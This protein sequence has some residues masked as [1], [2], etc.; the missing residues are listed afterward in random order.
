[1]P[2]TASSFSSTSASSDSILTYSGTAPSYPQELEI[3]DGSSSR[4]SSGSSTGGSGAD[5]PLM[6]YS[7]PFGPNWQRDLRGSMDPTGNWEILD[8]IDLIGDKGHGVRI[9]GIVMGVFTK[10][11]DGVSLTYRSPAN[12]KH[13]HNLLAQ[14]VTMITADTSTDISARVSGLLPPPSPTLARTSAR[15]AIYQSVQ[16]DEEIRK[17]VSKNE[18]RKRL[19]K[20]AKKAAKAASR[21]QHSTNTSST[22]RTGVKVDEFNIDPAKIAYAS[23]KHSLYAV[24]HQAVIFTTNEASGVVKEIR[25]AFDRDTKK[26]KLFIHLVPEGSSTAEVRNPGIHHEV[27]RRAPWLEAE[28]EKTGDFGPDSVRFQAMRVAYLFC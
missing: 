19:Q 22:S 2:H 24:P 9:N 1:M 28:A 3:A 5:R 16:I 11:R 18:L 12:I 4:T 26:P 10:N 23:D 8:G 17:I 21:G 27:R 25:A 13:Q 6:S 14:S 20:R 15:H 7:A